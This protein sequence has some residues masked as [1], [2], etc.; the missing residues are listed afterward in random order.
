M[1]GARRG[2]SGAAGRA[3]N[4]PLRRRYDSARSLGIASVADR[5][6]IVRFAQ[7]DLAPDKVARATPTTAPAR[8]TTGAVLRPAYAV[9]A[10]LRE[11]ASCPSQPRGGSLAVDP[12]C[13]LQRAVA[14]QHAQ[15]EA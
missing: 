3:G 12:G 13:H 2:A 10:S 14:E 7:P 11:R 1:F 8:R 4:Q 15:R 9:S 5:L 6:T